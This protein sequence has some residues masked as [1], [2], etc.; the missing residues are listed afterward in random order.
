M[1]LFPLFSWFPCLLYEKRLKSKFDL[2][3][4]NN[5]N[6]RNVIVKGGVLGEKRLGLTIEQY[7]LSVRH[8]NSDVEIPCFGVLA[9]LICHSDIWGNQN[10]NQFGL[11]IS[12]I[13]HFIMM[14]NLSLYWV[15]INENGLV[16][17]SKLTNRD[18]TLSVLSEFWAPNYKTPSSAVAHIY[19]ILVVL[20]NVLSFVLYLS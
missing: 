3:A 7:R 20:L 13:L 11:C 15:F 8:C 9:S 14:Q 18:Q 5:P 1:L 16:S 4:G 6:I 2:K 10:K 17:K 12:F 19:V